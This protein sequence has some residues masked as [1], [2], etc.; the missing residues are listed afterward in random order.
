MK[1]LIFCFDGTW[2]RLDADCPTNVVLVAEMTKPIASDG[3]PQIVYYDEGIG[4]A[5]DERFRGGAFGN[6]M[7]DNIREAY[8]FLLFRADFDHSGSYPQ[9]LK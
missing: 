7:M 3:S 6:G 5:K 9:E 8:R 1:R 2:N 4:T